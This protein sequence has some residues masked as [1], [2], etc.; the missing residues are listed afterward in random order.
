MSSKTLLMLSGKS[1]NLVD[2]AKRGAFESL[3]LVNTCYDTVAIG[4]T[5]EPLE[6]EDETKLRRMR[7]NTHSSFVLPRSPEI[8]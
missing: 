6:E 5:H 3:C 4:G 8:Q 7:I 2:L 1:L